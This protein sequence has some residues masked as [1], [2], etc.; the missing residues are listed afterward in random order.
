MRQADRPRRATG[1]AAPMDAVPDMPAAPGSPRSIDAS[2]P[3]APAA[4]SERFEQLI[5]SVRDYAIFMLDPRGIVTSWNPGAERIKGWRAEEIIGRS[6]ETFYPADAIAAGWP[7]EELRRAT[8]D[9]R[10][11]DLGWRVRKDGGLI[12]ANVVISAVRGADGELLGFAKVTRDLTE[13]RSH[14]EALRQ[15]EEQFRLLVESVTDYAIF[16]LDPQGHVLTW[17][18]GAAMIHGYAAAEAI[19]T[20]F[21]RFFVDEDRAAGLPHAELARALRDGRTENQGW[22]VRKDGT[23]FWAHVVL[24]PMHDA[25]GQLLGYAKVT[26][27]LTER[28][29]LVELERSSQRISEFI[30]M[31]AHELRNPLAPIRNAVGILEA[32]QDLPPAL[33]QVGAIVGRQTAQLT[34]LVDDLLD[35]ARISTGKIAL[36]RAP[37]DYRDV[38]RASVEASLP[39]MTARAQRFALDMADEALPVAGDAARLIQVLQNLLNN[40]AR[41]TPEGGTIALRVRRA[42]DRCESVVSDDGIGIAPHAL[43]RI[44]ELFAQEQTPGTPRNSGL[45]IGL[46]LARALVVQHDGQLSAHSEGLG[47]G[48]SFIVTLPL[49]ADAAPVPPDRGAALPGPE[50]ATPLRRVL[51]VD[52][53]RDSADTMVEL[54]TLLGHA[55]RAAYSV[56]QALRAADEFV[57]ECALLDLNMPDADGHTALRRLRER[58]GLERMFA[59]AMTGYGQPADRARTRSAGFDAHLTKP[60]EFEQLQQVLEQ[61]ARHG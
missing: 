4:G 61:A 2:L 12:W 22:R 34:R 60:V 20:H 58:P 48:S 5:S 45:G 14:Q 35:V 8:A 39:E 23:R 57:P 44:F 53:N 43:A 50:V 18:A 11:E 47:C 56:E 40:A 37:L 17:N 55:A 51:V 10:F 15:S 25:Q 41:Y 13:Q 38:V 1:Y 52:D 32:T 21:S 59:A 36:R 9:G 27:D 6:F 3:A 49:L 42:G 7:Q 54:L 24:T 16:M 28:R 19:G 46:A 33:A 31:L 29:R 26:R 30:A